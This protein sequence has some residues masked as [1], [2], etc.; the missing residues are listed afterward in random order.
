MI[1]VDKNNVMVG[2]APENIL[3]ELTLAIR[4]ARKQLR[5]RLP[6]LDADDLVREAI[7]MGMMSD[8]DF[9]KALDDQRKKLSGNSK[10]Q[11]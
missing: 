8:E 5:S 7:H 1:I 10:P 6:Y 9:E 4:S 2:G 11:E 3:A